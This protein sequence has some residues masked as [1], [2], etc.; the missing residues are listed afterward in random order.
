VSRQEYFHLWYVKNCDSHTKRVKNRL[1][2]L[3]EWYIS[4]KIGQKCTI[5]HTECTEKLKRRFDF[6]HRDPE[7]KEF[8]ISEAVSAG[9]HIDRIKEELKKCDFVCSQCHHIIS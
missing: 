6:H 3:K 9:Y 2:T 1:A 4:L 7:T 5:C 8:G